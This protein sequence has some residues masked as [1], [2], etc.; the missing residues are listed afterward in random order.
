MWQAGNLLAASP[1][2]NSL[3]GFARE[4][5]GSAARLPALKSRQLRRLELLEHSCFSCLIRIILLL[6]MEI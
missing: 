6:F 2:V 4:Y 5:S 3:A 1:L